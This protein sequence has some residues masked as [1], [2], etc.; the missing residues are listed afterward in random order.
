MLLAVGAWLLTEAPRRAA[1]VAPLEGETANAE[2]ATAAP[3]TAAPAEA[4]A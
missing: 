2:P 1:A 3:A 4:T